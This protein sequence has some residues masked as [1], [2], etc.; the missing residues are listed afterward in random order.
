MG[1]G[2]G[3]GGGGLSH[4][5]YYCILEL[6]TIKSYMRGSGD[7]GNPLYETVGLIS[8]V[9]LQLHNLTMQRK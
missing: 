3:G 8:E 9:Q 6:T 4:N 1:G 2:G 5:N 7:F